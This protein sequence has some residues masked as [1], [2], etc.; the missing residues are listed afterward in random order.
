LSS[1]HASPTQSTR[2]YGGSG[3]LIARPATLTATV[4]ASELGAVL[5]LGGAIVTFA[6]GKSMLRTELLNALGGRSLGAAGGLVDSAVSAA[7]STLQSRAIL[8]VA[9]AVML[10]VLAL[11]TNRE[12]RTGVRVGLTVALL[13]GAAVWAINVGDGGVP[14]LIRALDGAAMIVAIVAIVL[15]WLPQNQR[16]AKDS[17]ALRRS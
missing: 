7:Y 10:S 16:F 14:G 17:R 11:L 15:T 2:P 1:S 13:F 8:A 6:A 5:G 3:G 4:V 12:G 9:A